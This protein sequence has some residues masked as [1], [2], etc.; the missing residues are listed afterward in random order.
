MTRL[1]PI[2][3]IASCIAACS[4]DGISK[5]SLVG[6]W[7]QTD[8]FDARSTGCNCW[9][10]V[11][12]IGANRFE[13]KHDG[14]YH[15]SPPMYSSLYICPGEYEIMGDSLRLTN[16]CGGGIPITESVRWFSRDGNTLIIESPGATGKMKFKKVR[17]F[18]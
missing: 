15:Q 1:I 16:N 2:L 7:L 3:L 5:T 6:K 4:K 10:A 17:S 18:Y 8:Y 14:T 9:V 11:N 12:E 13:F